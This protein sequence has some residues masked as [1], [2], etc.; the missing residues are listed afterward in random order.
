MHFLT[1]CVK[2]RAFDCIGNIAVTAENFQIAWDALTDRHENKRRLLNLH[3]TTLFNLSVIPRESASDIQLLREKVNIAISSLKKLPRTPAELWN[4]V[5]VHIVVQR[6]DAV[7]RKAWN[8]KFCDHN[9]PPTFDDLDRFLLFRVRAHEEFGRVAG[10]SAAKPAPVRRVHVATASPSLHLSCPLCKTRHYLSVFPTF[11]R[12]NPSRRRDLVKQHN[13]CFNCLS[14]HRSMNDCGS[15]HSCRICNMKHHT[16]L[17]T[18]SDPH[19][20]QPGGSPPLYP[21]PLQGDSTTNVQSLLAASGTTPD[22]KQILLA[23]AWVTVGAASGRSA[24]VRA[25]LDQGSKCR[26]FLKTLHNFCE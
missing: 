19:A 24:V 12:V 8:V 7:T 23:T 14:Q 6:L 1:S 11:V 26:L 4:D 5:L 20:G 15:K 18:G 22:Q 2:E 3:L 13:R 25:L 17:H 21:S 10:N 16:M 9:N